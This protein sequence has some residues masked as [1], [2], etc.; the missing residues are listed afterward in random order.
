MNNNLNKMF[1]EMLGKMDDKVIQ[2]KLN[3][4]LDMLKN[5]N[6]EELAKKLNKMDKNELM[7]KINEFDETKLKEL[8]INKE[9]IKQKISNADLEKLSSLI[10]ENG[11]E[12]VRKFK[13]FLK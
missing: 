10:D 3:A 2:A 1:S 8:N 9:E 7:N 11:D 4:A 6:T 12:L 13:D 5:G